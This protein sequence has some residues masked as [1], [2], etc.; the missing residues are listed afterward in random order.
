MVRH[1]MQNNRSLSSDFAPRVVIVGAGL[2]GI[3]AAIELR[4][5]G[6]TDI[7]ILEAAD[8]LGGT[9][10]FNDYP[11]AA[12]D[13]PSQFYSFSYAQRRNWER[14]CTPQPQILGYIGDVAREFGVAELI[15]YRTKVTASHWSDED[16]TWRVETEGGENYTADVLIIA[17]GQLNQPAYPA[18]PGIDSFQGDAF[19]S[20]RWNHDVA[21][22][23]K[24]VAVVGTG[25]SAAQ[26]MPEVAKVAGHVTVFQRTGN[27]FMPRRNHRYSRPLRWAIK[28][29]PRFQALRRELAYHYV[30]GIT[31]AIRHPKTVG[32]ALRL[33]S[34]AFMRWQLRGHPELRR[35]VWPDYAFGCKRVLFSSYFL[36]ALTRPNVSLETAGIKEVT[37]TGLTTSDGAHHEFDCIIWGTGFQTTNF[38]FPMEITGRGG[39]SLRDHWADGAHAHLGMTVPGFPSMFVLYGPNTN[40][41]GGSIIQFL[42]I[43]ARYVRQALELMERE[44]ASAI[45]VRAEVEAASDRALQDAFGGTAWLACNSWYR[46]ADGRIVTNWPGYMGGYERRARELN[47]ADFTLTPAREDAPS[48]VAS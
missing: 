36:E 46:T 16:G 5:G 13:V 26:F 45:E 38:M 9:W 42:E 41:S 15:T 24:R 33:V 8:A 44:Q 43:Q 31:T 35:K 28:H 23:G 37:P 4:R 7:T 19:H 27:W 39:T 3:G 14:I 2:G 10:L 25:A 30:E 22:A 47:P 40:T 21:L 34:S 17:T 12:C 29:V 1:K 18:L 32:R 11:G 6:Y 20:A 48:T